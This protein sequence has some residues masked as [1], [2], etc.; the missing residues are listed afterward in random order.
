MRNYHLVRK[1]CEIKDGITHYSR[2]KLVGDPYFTE[3]CPYYTQ[4]P[5]PLLRFYERA[6]YQVHGW[7]PTL[8]GLSDG[9]GGSIK[10]EDYAL[11][12][13]RSKEEVSEDMWN[14]LKHICHLHRRENV[15]IQE[16][17]SNGM[18]L[19]KLFSSINDETLALILLTLMDDDEVVEVGER[20]IDIWCNR[21][22]L[23]GYPD[24]FRPGFWQR[25]QGE[26]HIYVRFVN[27]N[28]TSSIQQSGWVNKVFEDVRSRTEL[29]AGVSMPAVLALFDNNV[30]TFSKYLKEN[31]EYQAEKAA[32]HGDNL[33]WRNLVFRVLND[34][35]PGY[36]D[37][38][39]NATNIAFNVE[40]AT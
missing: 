15:D 21:S 7:N 30:L 2:I 6:F 17:I 25:H 34:L 5:C 37:V 36:W 11:V 9:A 39:L 16:S 27:P 18:R 32:E 24:A 8:V 1:F 22:A 14:H 38:S 26:G 12:L 3:P 31:L 20:A 29:V 35:L 10:N 4:M 13:A 19:I 23:R 40:V 28:A 33:P